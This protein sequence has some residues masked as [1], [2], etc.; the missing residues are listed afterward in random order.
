MQTLLFT[1]KVKNYDVKVFIDENGQNYFNCSCIYAKTNCI[2][3]KVPCKHCLA[4]LFTNADCS[5][6]EKMRTKYAKQFSFS[7]VTEAEISLAK[8]LRSK[9]TLITE[10]FNNNR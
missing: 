2:E 9:E 5:I 6:W 4:V 7:S 10:W 1:K 8:G 3:R